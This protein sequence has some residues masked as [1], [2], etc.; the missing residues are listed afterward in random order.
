MYLLLPLSE[1][2]NNIYST[3]PQLITFVTGLLLG[4]AIGLN[5]L[6]FLLLSG[7]SYTYYND[8]LL[9]INNFH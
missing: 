6:I 8:I 7:L 5:T 3:N 2:F 1:Y 9:F 4:G